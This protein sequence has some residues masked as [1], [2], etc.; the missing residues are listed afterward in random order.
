[1]N[2][3]WITR[4]DPRTG[5]SGELIYSGGLIRS[6]SGV[7][8]FRVEVVAHEV[9]APGA[10]RAPMPEDWTLV[11][12]ARRR[13][14]GSLA[15]ALPSDAF[16]LSGTPMRTALRSRLAGGAPPD[17]VVIDQAACGWALDIL[18]RRARR[19]PVVYI[20]HNVEAAIRPAIA[21]GAQGSLAR[22]TLQRL[23]AWKY[24]RLE[25]RLCRRA[26]LVA[27]IT[28]ADSA[29]FRARFPGTP[30]R[31]L[32]P[33][34]EATPTPRVPIT[35][36]TPRLAVIAGSFEWIAKQANL[37]DFLRVSTSRLAAAGIQ[38]Q[39]VG[40]APAAFVSSVLREFPALEFH[41]HVPTVSPYLSSARLGLVIDALGG[42]FKLKTL[43]YIFHG[44]PV[45][46]LGR[47]IQDLPVDRHADLILADSYGAL[48]DA[49]I[50]R[51][52]DTGALDAMR[53]RALEKCLPHFRWERRCHELAAALSSLAAPGSDTEPFTLAS[54]GSLLPAAPSDCST[55][56]R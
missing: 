17:A 2:I 43:D 41:A 3:L 18:G 42:G 20:A 19:T 31:T 48:A 37:L 23:D 7:S 55:P 6:L 32:R 15:G 26:A 46:G 49:M 35:A 5:D 16:R 27:A 45:A 11:R 12:G 21:R 30:V 33:G 52:D 10:A 39:V 36:H 8:G 40:K 4:Q 25:D 38:I 56:E 34:Y 9:A 29:T 44:L 51:I 28:D 53:H 14:V 13:R 54:L 47:A 22:R 1:M 50:D 24:S